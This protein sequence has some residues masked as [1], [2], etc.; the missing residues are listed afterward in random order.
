MGKIKG[1]WKAVGRTVPNRVGMIEKS[2]SK[3][4]SSLFPLQPILHAAAKVIFLKHK[5]DH[6]PLLVKRLQ[7]MSTISRI[8]QLLWHLKSLIIWLQFI[9]PDQ[10]HSSHPHKLH[11]PVKLPYLMFSLSNIPSFTFDDFTHD[12][13]LH[14]LHPHLCL[15]EAYL[16]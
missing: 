3:P 16:P 7:E 5:A 6:A 13:A 15:L 8:Q 1:S 14:A 12:H 2:P 4:A 9:F 10:L 11:I